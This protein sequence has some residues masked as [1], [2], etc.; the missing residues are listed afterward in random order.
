MANDLDSS[1]SKQEV[2]Q[3]QQ[4][5]QLSLSRGMEGSLLLPLWWRNQLTLEA[6]LCKLFKKPDGHLVS[7]LDQEA[8]QFRKTLPFRPTTPKEE[9]RTRQD[10]DVEKEDRIDCKTIA[11]QLWGRRQV[12]RVLQRL[13][14][15]H[16]AH[17]NAAPD[18]RI[19]FPF[20]SIIVHDW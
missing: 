17:W 7:V 13:H 12:K 5:I 15:S 4:L 11:L 14:G 19:P 9:Q 3:Q 8:L 1:Y 16:V 18:I 6:T 20:D 2:Q 10:E